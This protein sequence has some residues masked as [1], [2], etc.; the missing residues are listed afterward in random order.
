MSY[1]DYIDRTVDL[2]VFLGPLSGVVPQ[3]LA[4]AD[5]NGLSQVV[6]GILKLSQRFLVLLLTPR[7]SIP[8][9]PE[10]GCDFMSQL[11]RGELRS[12]LDVYSAFSASVV[13]IEDQ[14]RAK[15]LETAPDDEKFASATILHLTTSIDSIVMKIQITSQ[16]GT[17]R[18][19]ILP[20]SVPL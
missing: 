16:A 17:S 6:T 4:M 5:E 19:V 9:L 15:E 7:G 1:T 11:L 12:E 20:T 13:D 2:A 14:L 18:T 8:H 3:E 10:D